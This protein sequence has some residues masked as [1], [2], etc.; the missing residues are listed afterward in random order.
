MTDNFKRPTPTV[1]CEALPFASEDVF[2]SGSDKDES[3]EEQQVRRRRIELQ[4]QHYL[5]GR[6]LFV[7]SAHLRGPFANGWINPWA[8]KRKRKERRDGVG[9]APG[10]IHKGEASTVEGQ[11]V[12]IPEMTRPLRT[13]LDT[14]NA[15]CSVAG[16]ARSNSPAPAPAMK[17]PEETLPAMAKVNPSSDDEVLDDE[18]P[19]WTSPSTAFKPPLRT[20]RLHEAA[21]GSN[22]ATTGHVCAAKVATIRLAGDFQGSL[23]VLPPSSMLPAFETIESI[24]Q[25]LKRHK[26]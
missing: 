22:D 3:I 12:T 16:K 23:K 25:N 4:A 26:P 19:H 24:N 9:G 1:D 11:E 5:Q 14:H 2:Y 17:L 6:E 15:V 21:T 13:W 7:L 18:R 20:G 10:K 8:R